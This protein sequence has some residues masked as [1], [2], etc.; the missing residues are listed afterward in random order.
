MGG[1]FQWLQGRTT[2]FLVFFSLTGT[3]L[4]LLHKL[5]PTYITF[6]GVVLGYAIGHSIKEDIAA[7]KGVTG[8]PPTAGV[9][10]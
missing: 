5:D 6:V 8:D 3:G 4:Q 10:Q 1:L 9:P 2:A 7:A